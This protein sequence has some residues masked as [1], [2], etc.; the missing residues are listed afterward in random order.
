MTK[1]KKKK[2]IEGKKNKM[3]N[4]KKKKKKKN[5]NK[6]KNSKFELNFLKEVN[7]HKFKKKFI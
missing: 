4:S 5:I 7:L 2:N 3:Q 1:I 6:K